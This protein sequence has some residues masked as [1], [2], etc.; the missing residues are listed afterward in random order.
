MMIMIVGGEGESCEY[1]ALSSNI[2]EGFKKNNGKKPI[3]LDF[4]N[5]NQKDE[6]V[7]QLAASFQKQNLNTNTN[8]KQIGQ[9]W[10]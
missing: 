8:T 2:Q 7:F 3:I 10:L 4:F 9:N 5:G 1:E 6:L